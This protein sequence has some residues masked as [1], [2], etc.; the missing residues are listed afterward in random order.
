MAFIS[1]GT[2]RGEIMFD[3]NALEI[4]RDKWSKLEAV[5]QKLTQVAQ[6]EITHAGWIKI[7]A[8]MVALEGTKL[9]IALGILDNRIKQKILQTTEVHA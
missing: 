7:K 2:G 1:Q 4:P 6:V 5:V 8:D 9:S 3:L